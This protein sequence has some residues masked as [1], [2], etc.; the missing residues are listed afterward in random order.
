MLTCWNIH[1]LFIKNTVSCVLTECKT[2]KINRRKINVKNIWDATIWQDI[3]VCTD[4]KVLRRENIKAWISLDIKLF[5]HFL[6]KMKK[7]N[8]SPR[9]YNTSAE[10]HSKTTVDIQQTLLY[11]DTQWR[12][13]NWNKL[14]PLSHGNFRA[15]FTMVIELIEEIMT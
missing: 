15:S 12:I 2:Q 8:V 3:H 1:V 6:I 5:L 14:P 9:S 13:L 4:M 7:L 10:C 11:V